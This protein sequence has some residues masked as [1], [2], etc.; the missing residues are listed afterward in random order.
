MRYTY[1]WIW[2]LLALGERKG[3]YSF[4]FPLLYENFE[5]KGKK[6]HKCRSGWKEVF[7]SH[8]AGM[9][10]LFR[11]ER[12]LRF[13][14]A[15]LTQTSSGKSVEFSIHAEFC[16]GGTHSLMGRKLFFERTETF[17]IFEQCLV[18]CEWYQQQRI[19]LGDGVNLI[20]TRD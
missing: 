19:M 11:K 8:K 9:N 7:F 15:T 17:F 13:Q 12:S 1:C 4:V 2:S 5:D 3:L 6:E 14:W 10:N 18:H 20:T 16:P